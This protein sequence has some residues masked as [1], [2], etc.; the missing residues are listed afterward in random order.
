MLARLRAVENGSLHAARWIEAL[1]GLGYAGVEQVRVP[2]Q[3]TERVGVASDG[4]DELHIRA[5]GD[6]ARYGCVPEVME[7]VALAF[8]A[9]VA[10]RGIRDALAEVRRLERRAAHRREAEFLGRV[11]SALDRSAGQLAECRVD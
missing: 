6:Q 11:T 8:E 9:S 10:K 4:V 1:G 5:C 2:L 3:R 7:P